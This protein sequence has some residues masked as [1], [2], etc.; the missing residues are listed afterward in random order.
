MYPRGKQIKNDEN[1]HLNAG[2]A[3]VAHSLGADFVKVKYP[4]TKNTKNTAKSYQE[5]VNAAGNTGVICVGGSQ[6]SVNNYLKLVHE[7]IHTAKTQG[8]A[9]GRNIHQRSLKDAL[10][11]VKALNAILYK[12]ASLKKAQDIYNK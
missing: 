6:K 2:A 1:I 12:N 8:I 11:L 3:G 5:V 9:V 4:Y 10:K 7:Q